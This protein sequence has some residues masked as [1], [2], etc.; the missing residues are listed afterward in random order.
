MINTV[1][2]YQY[3]MYHYHNHN[4][5]LGLGFFFF[6]FLTVTHL[7]TVGFPL[8]LIIVGIHTAIDAIHMKGVRPIVR[9]VCIHKGTKDD[10]FVV[11]Y[12][13]EYT[14]SHMEK[15][16]LQSVHRRLA[17]EIPVHRE[18]QAGL[19]IVEDGC[20]FMSFR[21]A[22][23]AIAGV[24]Y[25]AIRC[26]DVVLNSNRIP[27]ILVLFDLWN[28]MVLDLLPVDQRCYAMKQLWEVWI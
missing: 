8:L 14:A 16:V 27:F 10:H 2:M 5:S 20:F 4:R 25:E 15:H 22:I 9:I 26:Y 19:E 1:C 17:G 18:V 28:Q 23:A 7:F 24:S 12:H 21:F 3:C 13:H 11:T 6:F